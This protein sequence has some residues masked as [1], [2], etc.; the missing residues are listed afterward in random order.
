MNAA[1][2]DLR[3]LSRD[4]YLWDNWIAYDE[5]AG[6]YHRY[7]LG[8]PR[9]LAPSERHA[10]ARIRHAI[11]D[12]GT[13]WH[14]LGWALEPGPPG[15]H[16]DL[17]AWTGT[18]IIAEGRF[19][20][21]YTGVANRPG[22]P[23]TIALATSN[24]GH[25]FDRRSAPLL[26]PTCDLGYDPGDDDG[27]IMAWRDPHVARDPRTG[28]WH[29][30]FAC[31][32]AG[33]APRGAIGHAVSRGDLAHWE[34]RPPLGL[35]AGFAQAEVPALVFGRVAVYCLLSTKDAERDD[36][37]ASGS[38][39]RVFAA[40]SIE[41]PWEAAAPPLLRATD[42]IYGAR[43]FLGPEGLGVAAFFA[44]DHPL[45]L[46]PTPLARLT[47]EPEIRLEHDSWISADT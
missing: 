21:L 43:P 1:A 16:D 37:T 36:A 2:C 38:A 13:R 47:L 32:R 17:A 33:A 23:Q 34:L 31:K 29:M 6:R 7:L 28:L 30:V 19:S 39:W 14:D 20:L 41:G 26:A 5:A 9:S 15:A 10:R 42:R 18:T 8:A 24:D 46:T 40:P 35:P 45:G 11:S 4:H 3:A 27:V 25:A 12:C 44:P 22:L